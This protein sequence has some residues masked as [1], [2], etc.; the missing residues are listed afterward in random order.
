MAAILWFVAAAL[1]LTAVV[2]RYARQG[3]IYLLAAALFL[4]TMGAGALRRPRGR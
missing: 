4:V 1:A 3:E 2:V